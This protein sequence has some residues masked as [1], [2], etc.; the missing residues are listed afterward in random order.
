MKTFLAQSS[1]NAG[2][3][4]PK[5]NARYDLAQYYKGL[6]VAD[7]V[8]TQTQGGVI[9][10]LGAEFIDRVSGGPFPGPRVRLV[11]FGEYLL[12]FYKSA[13][14]MECFVYQAATGLKQ[15]NI[16][17]SGNDYFSVPISSFVKFKYVASPDGLILVDG[18]SPP[19][20]ITTTSATTWTTTVITFANVPQF[21]FNDASSPTPTSAVWDVTLPGN[22]SGDTIRASV[23]G[24]QSEAFPVSSITDDT[25]ANIQL[26]FQQV[27]NNFTAGDVTCVLKAGTTYTVTFANA[28]ADNYE[29]VNLV[30]EIT[31]S[32]PVSTNPV[33]TTPGVPRKEDVWSATRGYPQTVTFHENR[34]VFG[35]TNS[36]PQTVWLSR[37]GEYFDFK[38]YRSLDNEAIDVTLQT[39]TNS[40]IVNLYSDRHLCVFTEKAE[41]YCPSIPITPVNSAFP[42]QTEFGSFFN[43]N[44]VALDNQ[45]IFSHRGRSVRNFVFRNDQK[46]YTAD[47]LSVA[48]DNVINTPDVFSSFT[49]SSD[50]DANYLFTVNSDGLLSVL[51]SLGAEGVLSWTTWGKD[52]ITQASGV[53]YAQYRDVVEW[54]GELFFLVQRGI[55]TSLRTD[56]YFIERYR[57][58]DGI[59]L[60]SYQ[61]GSQASS[62]TVN[63]GTDFD[64]LEVTVINEVTGAVYEGLTV[65][66]G[67][68]TTP[69]AVTDYTVGLPFA[70]VLTTM[71]LNQTLSDGPH[72][73][74][75]KRIV[76]V[77]SQILETKSITVNGEDLIF[78]DDDTDPVS[79]RYDVRLSGWSVDARVTM[80][81]EGPYPFNVLDMIVEIDV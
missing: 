25:A 28:A 36:R 49:S 8:L 20:L 21:D 70:P 32:A 72:A 4:S 19:V 59:Y 42:Q 9:K 69:E 80:T 76:S 50:T 26:G 45:V 35:G 24:I 68:V 10:R 64:N 16:N 63:V 29:S 18:V 3:L 38:N 81:Q 51:N 74:E 60:D 33:N 43:C 11:V 7:N 78:P 48:A 30:P 53:E 14:Q 57:P 1:L 52:K 15:T 58:A 41:Y 66:A 46:A 22:T 73:G 75:P 13:T 61:R 2:I 56:N 12:C 39:T 5:M 17:G 55:G 54:E 34:L 77:S 67:A 40:A 65:S 31:S 37:T 23:N 79:G 47:S 44:V 6:S 71:P 62:T 27:L